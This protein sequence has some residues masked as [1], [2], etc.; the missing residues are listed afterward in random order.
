MKPL[1]EGKPINYNEMIDLEPTDIPPY[2]KICNKRHDHKKYMKKLKENKIEKHENWELEFTKQFV[3]E[4]DNTGRPIVSY[5]VKVK[6]FIKSVIAQTIRMELE[7]FFCKL[8]CKYQTTATEK[9][10]KTY[11]IT[12]EI[13]AKDI[14]KL[15]EGILTK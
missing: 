1:K 6:E 11:T 10:D 2:C 15:K 12:L 3:L 14:K 9:L 7:Q 4:V 13:P 5:P 8:V